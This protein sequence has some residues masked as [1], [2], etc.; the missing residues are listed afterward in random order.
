MAKH[1]VLFESDNFIVKTMNRAGLADFDIDGGSPVVL[2][3]VNAKDKECY[4]LAKWTTGQKVVYIAYN[5][6]VKYDEIGGNLYPARSLD[7]R[8]YFNPAGKVVDVFRPT[9]DVEFGIQAANIKST[10]VAQVSV[11][12]FLEPENGTLQFVKAESQTPD[13]PSFEVVDI[14]E[15]KYPT[16]TFKEDK[17]KVYIVRTRFNG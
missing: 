4:D 9:L 2:G 8:N 11:G 13:T 6:S 16:G 5:P 7:D 12:K 17:E 1:G 10:D 3:K 14:I 15:Q